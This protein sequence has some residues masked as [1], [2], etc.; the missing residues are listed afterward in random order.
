GLDRSLPLKDAL[1]RLSLFQVLL[2]RGGGA[3]RGEFSATARRVPAARS[4]N[5]VCAGQHTVMRKRSAQKTETLRDR[6]TLRPDAG[7][8]P[9][10]RGELPAGVAP[11]DHRCPPSARV[12]A[13]AAAAVTRGIW[14][15]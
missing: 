11:L 12:M 7:N 2:R 5:V 15:R 9:G 10:C 4:E 13:T 14:S 6:E 8:S 3:D 1:R